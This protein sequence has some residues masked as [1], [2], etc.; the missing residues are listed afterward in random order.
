MS[1]IDVELL[2]ASREQPIRCLAASRHSVAGDWAA[3][4]RTGSCS[5]LAQSPLADRPCMHKRVIC[6]SRD[7]S[8]G[9]AATSGATSFGVAGWMITTRRSS[10]P[11]DGGVP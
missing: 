4:A 9:V 3:D 10:A 6:D 5:P 8:P 7:I 11:P 1:G 2:P